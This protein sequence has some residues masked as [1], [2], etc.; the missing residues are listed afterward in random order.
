MLRHFST[1]KVVLAL[2]TPQ[3]SVKIAPFY[4]T[5]FSRKAISGK[6]ST[7]N[8][9]FCRFDA[10]KFNYGVDNRTLLAIEFFLFAWV[11]AR[12]YQD[13]KKPRSANVDPVFS[14]N[15]LPEQNEPGYPGMVP[16]QARF[17]RIS[18]AILITVC[19]EEFL[20]LNS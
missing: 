14:N 4:I 13:L 20:L 17:P 2:S 9:S 3:N 6:K 15:K 1:M 7:A 10:G 16:F 8:Q 19:G 11:E 18:K 12:R 5:A